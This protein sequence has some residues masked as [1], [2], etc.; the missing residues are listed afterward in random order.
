MEEHVDIVCLLYR[1]FWQQ[2]FFNVY[3]LYISNLFHKDTLNCVG[4]VAARDRW[5][6][7]EVRFTWN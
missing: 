3:I 7:M 2:L 4:N 1:R 5:L 6:I